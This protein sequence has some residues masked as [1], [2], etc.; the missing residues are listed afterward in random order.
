MP[1]PEIWGPNIWQTLHFITLGY[2]NNPSKEDKENYKT[3]FLLFKNVLPCKICT[4]H[5][6]ENL[7][8]YPLTDEIL[9]SNNNLILWLIDLH[10]SVNIN[11]RLPIIRYDNAIKKIVENSKCNHSY[12]NQIN[13]NSKILYLLF[14]ILGIL[15]IIAILYKKVY[16]KL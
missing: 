5:Y 11:N 4:M 10:N 2:P 13:P 8:K 6:A 9:S 15:I 16:L 1:G 7:K 3:F 14:I 12:N